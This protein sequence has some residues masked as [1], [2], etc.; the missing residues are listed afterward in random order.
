MYSISLPPPQEEVVVLLKTFQ[1][2]T[3]FLHHCC[4]HSKVVKDTTLI[5]HVPHLKKTLEVLIFRVK[6]SQN[7]NH[8]AHGR[9]V[10]F[11]VHPP[12]SHCLQELMAVNNC[13]DF[14]WV[15]NL[16]NR[17]LKVSI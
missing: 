7:Q 8:Q 14:F 3:R 1:Q 10:W 12:L 9:K 16:K 11:S 5:N 4:G 2:S 13:Q 17:D 15:G 6:V